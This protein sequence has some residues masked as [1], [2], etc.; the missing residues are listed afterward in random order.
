MQ[1]I[2]LE[3]ERWREKIRHSKLLYSTGKVA[4]VI[5]LAVEVKGISA[6]IGEVCDIFIPGESRPVIAEVVGF[7]E[8]SSILMPLGELRGIYPG[9]LVVP[10]GR[11]FS[12]GVGKDLLGRVLNGIGRPMDGHSLN[13]TEEYPVENNPPDPL[14]RKH[15]SDILHTGVRV[16]DALL[17]CGKGQRIGIFAGSGVGKSTLLGM[18]ARFCNADLNVIALIGERG[19]EVLDFIENDLGPDGLA[20]S[21]VVVATSDQP[22]LVRLKGAFVASAI[23]E[24][25]R[26]QGKDVLLF[27]DS[28]TRFAM[29][30]REVGLAVGEPPA[31]KGYTPSVFSLLPKLLERSGTSH[32]GTITAFYTVLVEADDMN[33]P[34]ADAVRGILD[35]HI[36]LSRELAARGHYPAVD[37]LHS[38]SRVMPKLVTPEHLQAAAR[39]RHLLAT[40]T[41]SEDLINVGAY[42]KGSNPEIDESLRYHDQIIA[43]LRQDVH[44]Q[45]DFGKTAQDLMFLR[46]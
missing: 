9:C 17:T 42:V 15:I 20:R 29:A 3:I 33:E 14:A 43:F 12:V 10:R 44:E 34:V 39:L 19:R 37:V 16:I 11:P 24:Y 28:V 35:G 4:R 38:V 41:K 2:A 32:H 27:M 23:A 8:D 18:I 13:I 30:Q 22:A 21:V 40:Y 25:F 31:T 45:I 7:K 26:D 46:E 36:V 5:G 1:D 6:G